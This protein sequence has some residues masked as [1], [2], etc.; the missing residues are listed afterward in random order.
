MS[1]NSIIVTIDSANF[2]FMKDQ[3]IV[4]TFKTGLE[5]KIAGDYQKKIAALMETTTADIEAAK[6]KIANAAA[7]GLSPEA[8]QKKEKVLESLQK[9]EKV[10]EEEAAAVAALLANC[11][12]ADAKKARELYNKVAKTDGLMVD[13]LVKWFTGGYF[14]AERHE[15]IGNLSRRIATLRRV[16]KYAADPVALRN[17]E[18]YQKA[19]ELVKRD[20]TRLDNADKDGKSYFRRYQADLKAH[21]IDYIT[22][23][24]GGVEPSKDSKTGVM[25]LRP[26]S[27]RKI[28]RILFALQFMKLQGI[29][30]NAETA[31]DLRKLDY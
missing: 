27:N 10:L 28:A 30:I 24:M 21:E 4:K 15:E 14:V 16:A 1:I 20:F 2:R 26:Y 13:Y 7:L 23:L 31:D 22:D 9:K 6:A 3:N 18:E 8:L 17:T 11:K 5:L 12:A 25:F 19:R 29:K